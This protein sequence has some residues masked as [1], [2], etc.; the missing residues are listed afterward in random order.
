MR[1]WLREAR[2]RATSMLPNGSG[3]RFV[4]HVATATGSAMS[5][6]IVPRDGGALREARRGLFAELPRDVLQELH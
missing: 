4:R 3:G 1:S 6:A 5:S 2:V